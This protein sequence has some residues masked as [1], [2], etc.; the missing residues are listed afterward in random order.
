[1]RLLLS[2]TL[3]AS[4]APQAQAEDWDHHWYCDATLGNGERAKG[5]P[6]AFPTRGFLGPYG[7]GFSLKEV[8]KMVRNN[9]AKERKRNL[10]FSTP[11]GP[12]SNIICRKYKIERPEPEPT[13][14]ECR[15]IPYMTPACSKRFW[16]EE[17]RKKAEERERVRRYCRDNPSDEA[18]QGR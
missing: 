1:M 2:I 13:L 12:C 7:G 10:F 17:W 14:E 3:L 15:A 6:H 18:C 5:G 8:Q 9:C 16:E 11:I 4:L